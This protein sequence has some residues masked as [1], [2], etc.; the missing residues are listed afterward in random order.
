[1]LAL[2]L[3]DRKVK[4]KAEE[5]RKRVAEI[6]ARAEKATSGPWERWWGQSIRLPGGVF[7]CISFPQHYWA[8]REKKLL[9]K[10]SWAEKRAIIEFII[11]ARADIPLLCEELL[12]ALDILEKNP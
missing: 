5:T 7:I 11:E 3:A 9:R 1:M 10:V 6:Q 4:M 12:K 2:L 8:G